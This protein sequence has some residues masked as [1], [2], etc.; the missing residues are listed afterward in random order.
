MANLTSEQ[1]SK[2]SENFFHL[3]T[4]ILDFRVANWDRLNPEEMKEL[5]DAQ[6]SFLRFGEDI[7]AFTTTLIMD[8]VADS[9]G[10]INT[11]TEEIKGT[12]KDLKN[13]QKG[14]NVAAGILILG[15]AILN[16]DTQGIGTSLKDV[17]DVWRAPLA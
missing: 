8:E 12:I 1:A 17:I 11:I 16:R 9:L 5:S 10:K 14:L 2:L 3:S 7:L 13:I 6:Y 15:V 4:A